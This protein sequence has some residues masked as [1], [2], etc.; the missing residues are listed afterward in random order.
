M[1]SSFSHTTHS[2]KLPPIEHMVNIFDFEEVAKQVMKKE[3]W[4]YY[5]SGGDDEICLREN[6][7]AFQRIWLKP[8]V[9]VD[10]SNVNMRS[11]MLGYKCSIP[12]YISATALAKLAHPDGEVALTRAA[13]TQDIIQMCPTLSSCFNFFNQLFG[14]IPIS[15]DI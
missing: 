8:R 7:L 4:D 6:H 5:S 9:M 15:I 1:A 10:V 13:F 11:D 3:S 2:H 12:L 14:H